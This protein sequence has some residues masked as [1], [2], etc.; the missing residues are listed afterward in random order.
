MDAVP[1]ASEPSV[2]RRTHVHLFEQFC[3]E[4]CTDSTGLRAYA[5]GLDPGG[6]EYKLFCVLAL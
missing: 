5:L 2:H 6:F 3:H 1:G 4:N